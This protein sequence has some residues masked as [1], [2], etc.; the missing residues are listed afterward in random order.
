M[1]TGQLLGF[2]LSF[3]ACEIGMMILVLLYRAISRSNESLE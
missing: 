3:L 1:T 2:S